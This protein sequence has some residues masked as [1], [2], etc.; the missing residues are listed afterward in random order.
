MCS[1]IPNKRIRLTI[2]ILREFYYIQYTYD[3][4]NIYIHFLCFNIFMY[5]YKN[6]YGSIGK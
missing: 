6:V 4:H 1:K 5:I 3:L 2:F